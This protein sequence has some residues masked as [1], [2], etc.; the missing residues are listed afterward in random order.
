[1]PRPIHHFPTGNGTLEC[2]FC[3]E[4][5]QALPAVVTLKSI[6]SVGRIELTCMPLHARLTPA[7][8]PC[9]PTAGHPCCCRQRLCCICYFAHSCHSYHNTLLVRWQNKLQLPRRNTQAFKQEFGGNSKLTCMPLHAR[10][11]P[12]SCP[13]LPTAGHPCCCRQRLCLLL[14]TLMPLVSQHTL[15]EMAKQTAASAP[16]HTGVQARILEGTPSS[17]VCHCMPV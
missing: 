9:L 3:A 13:C 16:K 15:S 2:S 6:A 4:I 7:S 1:M 8:C 11:T 12:A 5:P 10:L 14:C 17:L